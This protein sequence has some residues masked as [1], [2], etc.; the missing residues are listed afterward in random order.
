MNISQLRSWILHRH[1]AADAVSWLIKHRSLQHRYKENLL[2]K[3][4][5]G[6]VYMADGC[7]IHG[8]LSDRLR[9]MVSL[10]AYCRE[11]GIRFY[12]HHT[13]PFELVDYLEPNEYDWLLNKKNLS[14][15][16]SISKPLVMR[17]VSEDCDRYFEKRL[18][19][20][21]DS[22]QL[23]VYSNVTYRVSTFA[24]D[25]NTLFKPSRPLQNI[26]DQ[27]LLQIGEN[28]VSVTFRFQQLLGD[29]K[30]GKYKTLDDLSKQQ[31]INKCLLAIEQVYKSNNVDTILVTSDSKTFLEKAQQTFEYVAIIP[32]EV[33][34]ID[35]TDEKQNLAYIKSFADL[36][37][38][39]KA[40]KVYSY[41]TG[42]MYSEST[43]AE[44]GALIGGNEYVRFC[45]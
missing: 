42:E 7:I 2:S 11:Q 20:N 34:H 14:F 24:K 9:G 8:G 36:F 22:Q 30:E 12:I 37:V 44:T 45:D 31:L 1:W 10:Y 26:I 23:H 4:T 17:S 41:S 18:S 39:S 29:F 38:I 28:Y 5:D 40:K 27:V 43:F 16:R 13:S 25:F 19:A 6:I 32:G 3:S 15:D 33:K 35:Y 21:Y